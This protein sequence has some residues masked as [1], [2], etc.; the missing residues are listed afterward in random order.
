MTRI[1]Q[2]AVS[3][4]MAVVRWA[5]AVRWL[6]EDKLAGVYGRKVIESAPIKRLRPVR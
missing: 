6:D 5:L 2:P 3:D 1:L 4:M